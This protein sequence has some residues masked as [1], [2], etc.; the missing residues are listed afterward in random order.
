[1][2]AYGNGTPDALC[3]MCHA[4]GTTN[5]NPYAPTWDGK[6]S[7]SLVNTGVYTIEPNSVQDHTPY[8]VEECT[9]AGCHAMPTA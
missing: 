5:S 9:K 8:K 7:G 4:N 2:K 1:M 6:A 3:Q